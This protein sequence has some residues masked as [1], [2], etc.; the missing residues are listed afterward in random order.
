MNFGNEPIWRTNRH[1]P[2][3]HIGKDI[4]LDPNSLRSKSI[5]L[6]RIGNNIDEYV[7]IVEFKA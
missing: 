6:V 4:L 3:N 5:V 7:K 2:R 1:D